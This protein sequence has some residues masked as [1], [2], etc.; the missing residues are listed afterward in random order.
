MRYPAK[1]VPGRVPEL[2]ITLEAVN[3]QWR[4]VLYRR[5]VLLNFKVINKDFK[6]KDLFLLGEITKKFIYKSNTKPNYN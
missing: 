4:G 6:K 1:R 5:Q 3:R 2:E